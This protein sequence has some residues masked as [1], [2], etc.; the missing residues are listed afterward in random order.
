MIIWWK[1]IELNDN[2]TYRRSSVVGGCQRAPC[3]EEG[4]GRR[5][6]GPVLDFLRAPPW[7]L[8]RAWTSPPVAGPPNS[9]WVLRTPS[10]V[11][12]TPPDAVAPVD[13][14]PWLLVVV[15]PLLGCRW[16][17]SRRRW[18][19]GLFVGGD[20]TYPH[21]FGTYSIRP[22]VHYLSLPDFLPDCLFLGS[23]FSPSM[24]PTSSY[25]SPNFDL[26]RPLRP[27]VLLVNLRPRA[28]W[29]YLS[30]AE[31]RH[32][33][34]FGEY[35]LI[36]LHELWFV[37]NCNMTPCFL[38]FCCLFYVRWP[39]GFVDVEFYFISDLWFLFRS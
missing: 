23:S 10:W 39:F 19:F 18:G 12:R 29:P 7:I 35:R 28:Y 31:C 22:L 37:L 11:L 20:L 16:W 13:D 27:I 17:T 26:P 8:D 36:I 6:L 34:I 32:V 38:L 24:F 2:V 4:C 25:F 33:G 9:S 1:C 30:S 5:C 14:S 21:D 15:S 3:R